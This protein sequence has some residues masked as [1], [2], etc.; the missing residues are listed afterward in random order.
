MATVDSVKV[1]PSDRELSIDPLAFSGTP[2]TALSRSGNF[3]GGEDDGL[4]GVNYVRAKYHDSTGLPDD[5][6]NSDRGLLW[7]NVMSWMCGNK[8]SSVRAHPPRVWCS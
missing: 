8:P 1:S 2:L 3:A 4:V 5:D 7:N 6:I